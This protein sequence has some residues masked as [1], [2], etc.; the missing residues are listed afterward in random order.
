MTG[1]EW[2][3]LLPESALEGDASNRF[4]VASPLRVTHLRLNIFPDGG[5]AR[6]RVHGEP[7]PD[8]R[9]LHRRRRPDRRRRARCRA[10]SCSTRAT[11][12]SPRR[13]T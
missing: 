11:C 4:D 2:F 1:A 3:D 13:T 8:L 7:L 12:S 5:V 6:L 10:G 9:T